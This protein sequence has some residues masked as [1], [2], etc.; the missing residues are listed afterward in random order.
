MRTVTET[1]RAVI[2]KYIRANLN[3]KVTRKDVQNMVVAIKA[4]KRQSAGD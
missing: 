2:Y 3:L 4:E 1:K